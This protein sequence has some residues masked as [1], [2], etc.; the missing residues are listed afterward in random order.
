MSTTDTSIKFGFKESEPKLIEIIAGD[1]T[2]GLNHE[3]G[4]LFLG[5]IKKEGE[6]AATILK[7]IGA[8]V[9]PAYEELLK[10]GEVRPAQIDTFKQS[11]THLN[12]KIATGTN[13]AFD[14]VAHA[15]SELATLEAE[16]A[17][18]YGPV[19]AAGAKTFVKLEEASVK[20][21][22]NILAKHEGL[23]RLQLG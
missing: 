9:K 5:G 15:M 20:S 14:H 16:L 13:P 23:D 1:K 3:T 10:R 6:E 22:T 21:V 18:G 12:T 4:D 19:T 8:G 7:N 2:Y 17:K 11:I